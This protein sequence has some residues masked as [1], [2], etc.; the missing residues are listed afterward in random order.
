MKIKQDP[1]TKLWCRA[2]GT[3]LRPP[4]HKFPHFRWAFGS[5]IDRHGHLAITHQRKL[6]LVHRLVARAFLPN[7]DNLPTVDHL[8]RNPS[9]NSVDNLRWADMKTQTD[10]RQICEDSAAKYGVR[11]CEDKKAYS[12]SY[13]VVNREE[14]KVYSAAYYDAHKAERKAYGA[15]HYDA[16][17]EERK[18]YQNAYNAK[19]KAAGFVKRRCPDGKWRWIPK[20]P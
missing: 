4:C 10:N 7:P 15:A 20:R 8:D 17:R 16:H 11:C 14:R 12:K 13:N 6:Y 18:A 5:P 1:V 9:N 3:V 2:D 19:M